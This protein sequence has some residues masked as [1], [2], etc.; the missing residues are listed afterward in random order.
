MC[1]CVC[2]LHGFNTKL[3]IKVSGGVCNELLCGQ[4]YLK[5]AALN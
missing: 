3:K 2:A 5:N 4:T 1:E